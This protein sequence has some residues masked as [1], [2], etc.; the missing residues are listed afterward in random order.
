MIE[1]FPTVVALYDL[2]SRQPRRVAEFRLTRHGNVVL[3][4]TDPHGCL[5]A[6]QWYD[7]GVE[8]LG[9]TRQ[10]MP[11]DGAEFMKALLQPFRISY[12]CFVDESPRPGHKPR[13]SG[14]VPFPGEGPVTSSE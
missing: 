4:V 10:V 2:G 7:S 14:A 5:P 6:Q 12:Y 3:T 13:S 1:Q 8:I 9:E 11:D